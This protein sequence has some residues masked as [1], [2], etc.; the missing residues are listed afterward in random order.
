MCLLYE[1]FL[2]FHEFYYQIELVGVTNF[3]HK[4]V[5]FIKTK[6]RTYEWV[7]RLISYVHKINLSV[8]DQSCAYDGGS[9][10]LQTEDLG[11]VKYLKLSNFL[12][13]NSD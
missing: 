7:L 1:P 3:L 10:L 2:S 6:L 5:G 4:S 9:F 12:K 8:I 11:I 13:G